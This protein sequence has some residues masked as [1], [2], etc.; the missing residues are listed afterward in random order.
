[1]FALP[2]FP[3]PAALPDKV[4]VAGNDGQYRKYHQRYN[5]HNFRPADPVLRL[6]PFSVVLDISHI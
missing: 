6:P 5:A 2:D 4:G 1:L 3:R